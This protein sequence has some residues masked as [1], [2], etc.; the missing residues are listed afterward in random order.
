M[1]QIRLTHQNIRFEFSCHFSHVSPSN[2]VGFP[3]DFVEAV[4]EPVADISARSSPILVRQ[5]LDVDLVYR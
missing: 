1:I 4:I 2:A 5:R 3:T